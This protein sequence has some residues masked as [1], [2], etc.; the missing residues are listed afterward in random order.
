MSPT[1]EKIFFVFC[2]LGN[3][4]GGKETLKFRKIL[5]KL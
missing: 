4:E 3:G 5:R 1:T 2:G